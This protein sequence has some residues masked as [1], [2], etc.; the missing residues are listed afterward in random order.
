MKSIARVLSVE[1]HLLVAEFI[2]AALERADLEVT[3]AASGE[4]ALEIARRESFDLILLDV[5][6]PGMDGFEV[7]RR[8]KQDE[9]LKQIPVVFLTS[10]CDEASRAEGYQLGAVDYIPKPIATIELV[11]RVLAAL[12]RARQQGGS[13]KM[14]STRLPP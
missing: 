13:T 5:T 10:H 1:D 14:T 2:R 12:T 9:P 7:C 3:W 11:A 8:L 6:L 4:G